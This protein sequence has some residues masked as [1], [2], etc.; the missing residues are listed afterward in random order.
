LVLCQVLH[1]DAVLLDLDIPGINGMEGFVELRRLLPRG[2][3][4]ALILQVP[5]DEH[6]FQF[7]SGLIGVSL[8]KMPADVPPSPKPSWAA[9][10]S[11]RSVRKSECE[12][13]VN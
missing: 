1:Y 8:L 4:L 13:G 6:S 2:A 5:L 9:W 7:H 3:I 10:F 12:A 11:P